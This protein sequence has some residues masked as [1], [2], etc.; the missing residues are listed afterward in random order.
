MKIEPVDYAVISQSMMAVAREMG[1]KLVRSAYSSIVRDAKDASTGIMDASGAAVA[2]SDELIPILVNSLSQTFR[3]C[4]ALY[5]PETLTPDDFYISNHP[6]EGGQHLQDIFVFLPIFFDDKL[7]GFSASVAHHL[8]I[9]GGAPGLNNSA[10]DFYQEGLVIPPSRYSLSRDW[11][12][13]MFERL[14]AANVRVPQQ[15]I[16][17]INAQIAA[18]RVGDRRVRELCRKYGA[19]L[20]TGVMDEMIGYSERRVRAAISAVPDGVYHGR[21][22]VDDDGVNDEPLYVEAKVTVSGQNL[23][24]DY[25]GTSPQVGTNMNAPM[26]STISSTLSCLKSILTEYDVPFNEGARRAIS[27]KA[28]LGSLLNPRPPAPVRARMEAAYRAYDAVLQ[29]LSQAV[30]EMTIAPGYDSTVATCLS[31]LGENGYQVYLEVH[32]GG[33]GASGRADGCDAV[34]GPLSNCTNVPV[35]ALDMNFDFFRVVEYRLRPDSAGSG[36]YR[37][38]LGFV[39]TYKILR[40]NVQFSIYADRFRIPAQGAFGGEPGQCGKC[41]VLRGDEV[42]SVSSKGSIMLRAG[43]RLVLSTGG[44]GGYGHASERDPAHIR[45]DAETGLVT[46]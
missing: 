33:Y 36:R 12:G 6:Y 32:N 38:G 37:G 26:A 34:A 5:P 42:I 24:V 18:T 40:D 43:D 31:H 44:G 30:P 45:A 22:A 41:E 16:G 17:D 7:V 46:A 21:D 28:P 39:R 25:E 1:A 3:G 14:V 19:P 9:G 27:I 15:T 8:D 13:G 35:E 29:A 10:T 4:A 11:N 23:E 20:V 2:Q